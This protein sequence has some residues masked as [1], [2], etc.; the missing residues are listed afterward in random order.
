MQ[1]GFVILH[2]LAYEMTVQCVQLLLENFDGY[3][4]HIVIVDNASSNGSGKQLQDQFAAQENVTVLLNS[5][6][7]GFAKGNNAGYDYLKEH[8]SPDFI[9]VMNN[10]VLIK[11]SHF[12]KE[13]PRIYEETNFAV[14]GPDIFNPYENKHQNP[15]MTHGLS[16]DAA[17]CRNAE[18]KHNL[19]HFTSYYLTHRVSEAI[20]ANKLLK[21]IYRTIKYDLLKRKCIDYTKSYE[22]PHLHGACYIFSKDFIGARAHAFNPATF[23]YYEEDILHFECMTAHLKMVYSPLIRVEHLEDVSTNLVYSSAKK[24][25]RFKLGEMIRSSDILIALM[26]QENTKQN[27][28]GGINFIKALPLLCCTRTQQ[29]STA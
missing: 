20:K 28:G 4:M 24:K 25:E 29:R 2:Y 15:G 3:D 8:F 21:K 10:D 26:K 27:T 19:A 5:E 7:L 22:N 13:I 17:V 1:F 14:L 9:I 18:M 16:Y 11:D 12:L 6:N 23:L